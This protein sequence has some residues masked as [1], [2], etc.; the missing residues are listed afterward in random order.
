MPSSHPSSVGDFAIVSLTVPPSKVFPSQAKHY[1]YIRPNAPKPPTPTSPRELF[2]VNTPVDTTPSQI[3]ALFSQYLGG[4]RIDRVQFS[5]STAPAA[6][7]TPSGGKKRKRRGGGDTALEGAAAWPTT[8]ERE[9]HPS[10]DSCVVSFVDEASAAGA[11]KAVLRAARTRTEIPLAPTVHDAALGQARYVRLH[12]LQYPDPVVLQDSVDA[13]MATFNSAEAER[14][15][16]AAKARQMPDED[17]FITVTRGGRNN[18]ARA[19]EVQARLEKQKE[20]QNGRDDFYRFQLR[21]KRKDEAK[22][23]QRGFEEQRRRVQEMRGK[24]KYR[25]E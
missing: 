14:A 13:F 15:R 18:P 19:E 7:T 12:E 2:V 9:L 17:G 10:G 11:M 16:A 5:S 4:F 25:P 1:L 23:L 20:R 3:R 6:L 8:S 24:R 21:E 22:E